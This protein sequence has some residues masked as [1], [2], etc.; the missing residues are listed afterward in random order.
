MIRVPLIVRVPGNAGQGR[1]VAAPVSLV[2]LAPTILDYLGIDAPDAG[3]QGPS[4][5]PL[6]DGAPGLDLPPVR[7]EVRF[8]VLSSESVLAEKVAFKH[9]VIDGRYKLIKDFREQRY[10]LYDLERDPGE[11]QNLAS[12]RPELLREMLV[13]LNRTRTVDIAGPAV[14]ESATLDPKDAAMLRDLGYIDE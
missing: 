14:D 3:F 13:A 9:A 4:L 5:R 2:S 7:S 8:I 10:E 1:A 12:S 6:I 11:R